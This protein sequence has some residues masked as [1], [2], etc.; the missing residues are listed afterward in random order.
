M[1]GDE[2]QRTG[3][4]PNAQTKYEHAVMRVT[5]MASGDPTWDL[6]PSDLTCLKVVLDA[7]N[8]M[9]DGMRLRS[10]AANPDNPSQAE[11]LA[12]DAGASLRTADAPIRHCQWCDD[13]VPWSEAAI[14]S[15]DGCA[16]R[17]ESAA[18]A[19]GVSELRDAEDRT[20]M[21]RRCGSGLLADP[22]LRAVGGDPRVGPD[23]DPW[24]A[25]PGDSGST[26]GHRHFSARNACPAPFKLGDRVRVIVT[27]DLGTI[28][29]YAPEGSE[30]L[31]FVRLSPTNAGWRRTEDLDRP[32]GRWA[33]PT[34]CVTVRCE[35]HGLT[36]A[37]H[38]GEMEKMLEEV[39]G[40]FCEGEGDMPHEA[41]R[42]LADAYEELL[43]E[44]KD[45]VSEPV[46]DMSFTAGPSSWL[47]DLVLEMI[48]KCVGEDAGS[49]CIVCG[50]YHDLC[51]VSYDED[52]SCVVSRL[53]QAE[54]ADQFTRKGT[55]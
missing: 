7:L 39:P 53:L 48:A 4:A 15:C 14:V 51:H 11:P 47:A 20:M 6:S 22:P 13:E 43:G 35:L 17:R 3:D 21:L 24:A 10:E 2:K 9:T 26:P 8:A 31:W 1:S 32:I 41:V 18:I 25:P 44:I 28:E 38:C 5:L 36:E 42:R 29:Q 19:E 27:G 40:D 50:S 30:P 34:P 46:K 23:V 33:G 45:S 52:P 37:G 16:Q 49:K 55:P 12:K 54:R